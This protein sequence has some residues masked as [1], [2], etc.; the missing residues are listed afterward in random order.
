MVL[1][2]LRGKKIILASKSPR[3]Q[4]LLKGLDL[5]FEVKVS[6]V[7]ESYPAGLQGEEVALFLAKKKANAYDDIG[8]TEIIITADTVVDLDGRILEKPETHEEAV[9]MLRTLSGKQH[10]VYT[11]VCIKSATKEVLFFDKTVVQ[12][13]DFS[14]DEI[15]HYVE[16][17]QPFDKAGSYGAQEFLGYM[18]IAKLEGSYFNVMG[19]PTHKL[20]HALKSF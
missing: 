11:G 2:N 19:L 4:Q 1:Q 13:S 15:A 14:D 3:R 16:N 10:H 6:E 9:N 17:Y 5:Q 8:E 18:G 20:Y 12:F 7:N